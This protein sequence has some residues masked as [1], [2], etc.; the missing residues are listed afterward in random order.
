MIVLQDGLVKSH[1]HNFKF[2]D[3]HRHDNFAGGNSRNGH[4]IQHIVYGYQQLVF[5]EYW[6]AYEEGSVNFNNGH[7]MGQYTLNINKDTEENEG[8]ENRPN[9]GTMRIWKRIS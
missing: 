7:L 4:A 9:N 1:K 6:N 5:T 2:S 8:E 3:T